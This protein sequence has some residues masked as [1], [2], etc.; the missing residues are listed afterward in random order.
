MN[1][2]IKEIREL[3]PLQ[4]STNISNFL[5]IRIVRRLSGS[6]FGTKIIHEKKR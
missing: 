3:R 2:E 4:A 6:V 1:H 5:W